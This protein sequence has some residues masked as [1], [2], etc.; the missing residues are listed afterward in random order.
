MLRKHHLIETVLLSTHTISFG[1]EIRK[2]I[3][4]ALFTKFRDISKGTK[5]PLICYN[6]KWNLDR[7]SHSSQSTHPTGQ[8]LWEE[9]LKEVI[10]ITCDSHMFFIA[11]AFK[12]QV[13]VFAGP[14]KIVCHSSS[15]TSA[16]IE[17]FLSPVYSSNIF[18]NIS[19]MT[20]LI[21]ILLSMEY[22]KRFGHMSIKKD[23]FGSTSFR[24]NV[25]LKTETK[26]KANICKRQFQSALTLKAPRKKASE[27]VVCWSYL[28]LIIA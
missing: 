8:V 26:D 11:Y 3:W 28:L 23:A 13:D 15:G 25:I 19:R 24:E 27:N 5:I 20:A 4:Y 9:L 12:G 1:W 18:S 21:P 17:T 22:L 14:V 6:Y 16:I 10:Y 2:K 7:T